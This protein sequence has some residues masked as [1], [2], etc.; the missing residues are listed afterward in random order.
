MRDD[1]PSSVVMPVPNERTRVT[2]G[3]NLLPGLDGRT[4]W[5]RRVREVMALHISDLGDADACSEAEKSGVRRIS[6]LAIEMEKLERRF[7]TAAPDHI[8]H[9]NLDMYQRGANTLRRLLDMTGLQ[10]RS[11]DITSTLDHYM[12]GVADEPRPPEHPGRLG[13]PELVR[14]V[15][16]PTKKRFGLVDTP[17]AESSAAPAT[18]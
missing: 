17:S 2:N 15:V 3:R 16:S 1:L 7:A 8:S 6:V 4:Y 18:Y 11:R 9:P 5:A 10:R 13:R 14:Q 12:S